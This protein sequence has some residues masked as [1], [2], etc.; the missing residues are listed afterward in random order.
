MCVCVPSSTS[1]AEFNAAQTAFL[2]CLQTL[3]EDPRFE[4]HNL[5]VALSDGVLSVSAPSAG[6]W[7]LNKHG[8]TRQIWLSSPVSG[9]NKYNFH[10]DAEASDDSDSLGNGWRGERDNADTLKSRLT[11]EWTA[12]FGVAIDPVADFPKHT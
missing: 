7:V 10:A 3:L 2:D 1:A 5:D 11:R 8:P 6:T 12:A 9:P 4:A